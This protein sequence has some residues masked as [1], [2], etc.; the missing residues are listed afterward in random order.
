MQF[1]SGDFRPLWLVRQ[2]SQVRH[3]RDTD[4]PPASVR[5][6][7]HLTCLTLPGRNRNI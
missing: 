6:T 5:G 3:G 7:G 1:Q 2:R 4:K